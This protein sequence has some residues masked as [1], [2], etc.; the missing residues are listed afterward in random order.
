MIKAVVVAK[1]YSQFA[2]YIRNRGLNREHYGYAAGHE[3]SVRGLNK[4]EV[5]VLWLDGWS[6]N[7]QVTVDLVKL[8][9]LFKNHQEVGEGWIYGQGFSF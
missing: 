4:D 7:K 1:D 5:K 2:T 8:L 9:K 3:G 6:E